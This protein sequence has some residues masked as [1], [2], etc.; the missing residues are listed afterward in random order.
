VT[1]AVTTRTDQAQVLAG[2]LAADLA[3]VRD[4]RLLSL[5]S[6]VLSTRMNRTIREERQLVYS[7]GA[8]S[9]PAEAYPVFGV[10]AAQAPT[11][12][13]KAVALADALE[14]MFAAFA[15]QGPTEDELVVAKRQTANVLG[16]ILKGADFWSERLA[17]L[18]YRGLS[19]D[20][21]ARIADDL[22]RLTAAEVREAFARYARP[23]SSFRFVILPE[24]PR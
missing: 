23:D 1:R 15:V 4:S 18:T 2:F 13:A 20:D 8:Q 11:D 3:N 10:F 19:L 6:R 16:E 12:P 14:E 7:I 17:L 24:P 22:Q 21:L 5:A 9:R